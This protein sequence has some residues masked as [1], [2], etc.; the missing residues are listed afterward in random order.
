MKNLDTKRQDKKF[1]FNIALTALLLILFFAIGIKEP[2]FFKSKYLINIVLRNIIELG[3]MALPVTLIIIT[4]G[5]DLSVG[6]IATLSA[7]TGGMLF[8]SAGSSFLA[9]V[10]ALLVGTLCGLFNSVLVTRLKIPAMVT[11]LA[12]MYLFQGIA[13]GITMGESIY[14]FPAAEWLGKFTVGSIPVQILIYVMLAVLFVLLLSKN[15]YGKYLY[16]IGHNET[17]A[18]YAGINTDRCKVLAYA[19]CGFL[20]AFAGLIML[21]RFSSI[22]YTGGDGMNLKVVTIIVLGGTSINGGVGTMTGTIIAT[23]IVA[24]LNSGLT[25]LNI[26]IDVQTIVQGGVLLVSLIAYAIIDRKAVSRKK[27][28]LPVKAAAA[29]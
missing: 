16:A 5:I 28:K 3:I 19:M 4:G 10:A 7:I 12:T 13:R 21:G 2:A 14:S 29:K 11:T 26:P 20:S 22:K 18:R 27:Q 8:A 15:Y 23:L 9:V 1:N 17:A 6:S 25:V 24:V